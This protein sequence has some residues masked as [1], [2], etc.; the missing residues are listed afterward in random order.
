MLCINTKW[1]LFADL[2]CIC[3]IQNGLELIYW[4]RF[5]QVYKQPLSLPFSA[6]QTV[7][8]GKV[9]VILINFH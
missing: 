1:I 9:D 3:Q 2:K 6:S 4:N 5:S 8:G 7:A